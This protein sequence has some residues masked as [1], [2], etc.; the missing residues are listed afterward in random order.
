MNK[1][2]WFLLGLL[3]LVMLS[4][5]EAT[6]NVE[7]DKEVKI[8]KSVN[9]T[10]LQ[11]SMFNGSKCGVYR[12]RPPFFNVTGYITSSVPAGTRIFLFVAP[13][14]RFNDTMWLVRHCKMSFRGNITEEGTFEFSRV[15]AGTYVAMVPAREFGGHQGFPIIE[16]FE[17]QGHRAN[18]AWH[19]GDPKY[20]LLAF[21]IE[22]IPE[23][24][25]VRHY[26]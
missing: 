8:P 17:E 16:E 24:S 23:S 22:P 25:A 19:G 10:A 7:V 14:T 9:V 21:R 1:K 4:G 2:T 15:P 26:E 5:C 18:I 13:N 6:Q 20:S 11:K 3:I 12:F